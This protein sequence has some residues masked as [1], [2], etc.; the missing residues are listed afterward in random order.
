M[1]RR[2]PPV[3]M[4]ILLLAF[5][6]FLMTLIDDPIQTL[7]VLGLSVLLY[8]GVRHY[9]RYGSFFSRFA[10]S[11][12]P[13]PKNPKQKSQPFRYGSKKQARKPH[14][15]RVIDGHKGKS[16]EKNDRQNSNNLTQ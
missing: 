5:Y 11:R 7:I 16:R 4:I 3:V 14:P 10:S 8:L 15:F 12:R 9:L 2:I 1:F 13:K 6:G